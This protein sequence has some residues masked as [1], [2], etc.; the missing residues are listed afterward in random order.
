MAGYEA[1]AIEHCY[2]QGFE[3]YV[4]MM[5][6]RQIVNGKRVE[7]RRPRFK[8]YGFVSL[9]LDQDQWRSVNGTRGVRHLLPLHLER[10]A[11]LPIGFI[12]RLQ[13][14]PEKAEE[15]IIA[16]AVDDLVRFIAGPFASYTATIVSQHGGRLRA[17]LDIGAM[18]ET[19]V[20]VVERA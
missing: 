6:D 12:E 7:T 9:D 10:P 11:P 19:T 8:G 18:V 13:T 16:F 3:L 14:E 15:I 1:T 2:R 4:P 17:R 5:V 20:D